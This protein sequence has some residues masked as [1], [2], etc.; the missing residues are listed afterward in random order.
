MNILN[1]TRKLKKNSLS[2]NRDLGLELGIK[3][4][5]SSRKNLG[6]APVT[7]SFVLPPFQIVSRL[8]FFTPSLTTRL[9]QKICTNIVK[10]KSFLK[11]F[12]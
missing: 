2:R 3:A 4:L 1:R 10:F 6:L 7:F 5:F 9:I 11:N 12:Y 8:T